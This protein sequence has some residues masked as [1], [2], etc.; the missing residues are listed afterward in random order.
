MK[1]KSMAKPK[2]PSRT[3]KNSQNRRILRSV[4]R[5]RRVF[6]VDGA[7]FVVSQTDR[8]E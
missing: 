6:S 5:H 4:Y 1:R 7:R 2:M 8:P 3:K